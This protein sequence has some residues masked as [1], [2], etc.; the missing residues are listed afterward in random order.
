MSGRAV[1]LPAPTLRSLP[2]TIR[3]W[4]GGGAGGDSSRLRGGLW[5]TRFFGLSI[6]ARRLTRNPGSGNCALVGG[7]FFRRPTSAHGWGRRVG[8]GGWGKEGGTKKKKL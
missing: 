1:F 4:V 2:G 5:A 3:P 6:S 7:G 8:G